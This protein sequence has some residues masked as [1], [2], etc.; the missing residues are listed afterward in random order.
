MQHCNTSS[1]LL[2]KQTLAGQ[3]KADA[4]ELCLAGLA[5]TAFLLGQSTS[6]KGKQRTWLLGAKHVHRCIKYFRM[7]MH[8][9]TVRLCIEWGLGETVGGVPYGGRFPMRPV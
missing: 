2:V 1:F 6:Q 8:A 5:I 7:H 4:G 3:G 9:C